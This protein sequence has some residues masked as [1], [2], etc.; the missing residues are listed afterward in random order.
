MITKYR[1]RHYLTSKPPLLLVSQNVGKLEANLAAHADA[2]D[3][4][5][6][7][8]ALHCAHR[9]LPPVGEIVGCEQ[10]FDDLVVV[11]LAGH[12]ARRRGGAERR[13]AVNDVVGLFVGWVIRKA[14][15]AAARPSRRAI[16]TRPPS[17]RAQ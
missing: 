13:P 1:S 17:S 3:L 15:A 8:Q 6:V 10:A 7:D 12:D 9:H 4:A 5:V 14:S 16:S 11:G 2:V